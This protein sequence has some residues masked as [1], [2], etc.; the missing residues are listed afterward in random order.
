[1]KNVEIDNNPFEESHKAI[2]DEHVRVTNL[3][4]EK[5]ISNIIIF[6]VS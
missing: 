6:I 3:L 1:M 2:Y 5:R 4:P